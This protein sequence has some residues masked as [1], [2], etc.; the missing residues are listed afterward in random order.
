MN[1][2]TKKVT[3][4]NVVDAIVYTALVSAVLYGSMPLVDK[5]LDYCEERDRRQKKEKENET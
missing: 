4:Y 1:F 3:D 5:V 2:F